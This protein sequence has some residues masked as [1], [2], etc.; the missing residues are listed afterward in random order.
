MAYAVDQKILASDINGFIT[1]INNVFSIGS[2]NSGYGQTA[3][4]GV[5]TG[6]KVNPPAWSTLLSTLSTIAS[7]QGSTITAIT[8]PVQ[9]NIIQ[10][11]SALSTNVSTINTNRL[12]AAIQGS[13]AATTATNNI[14][15]WDDYLQFDFTITFASHNNARYF[16]NSGGQI[17]ITTS[18]PDSGSMNRVINRIAAAMGTIWLN[19]PSAGTATLNGI[20]YNGVTKIGGGDPSVTTINTNWGFYSWNNTLT[21]VLEQKETSFV[22]ESYETD[23]KATIS[24][25]YN[26]S[27]VIN[28]RIVFDEIPD[29]AF[30]TTGTSATV[31]IRNPSST[32]ITNT[33]GTPTVTSTVTPV[34]LPLLSLTISANQTNLDLRSYAISQGWDQNLELIVTI[35]G[36]TKIYSTSTGTPALTIA[37]SFPN[38]ITLINNGGIYGMGGDGGQGQAPTGNG[39]G[40]GTALSVSSAATVTNNGTIAGGGGG[41]G[42]GAAGG[43]G[44]NVGGGGGGG[45]G[46]SIVATSGGPGGNDWWIVHPGG[47]GGGGNQNGPGGGGAPPWSWAGYGGDGGSWG[48]AGQDGK[49]GD[50]SA[51]YP[52]GGTGGSGGAAV[53]GDSN[54]T[55]TAFGAIYGARV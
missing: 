48:Q 16:F 35:A 26:G 25:S 28:L 55:W 53:T 52:V 44:G 47:A 30:V 40:G 22:Y 6:S 1:T 50:N 21:Q 3:I 4:G 31:T 19:S 45:G 39:G 49:V 46:Q 17:G 5:I 15:S 24:V 13:T 2:G 9:K 32:Y 7:H 14:S 37:G 11:L 51:L 41:G 18:H 42:G 23:T 20:A 12:N 54:I 33:W 29:G 10:Y 36:P 34:S 27:G 43:T 8:A 38:G